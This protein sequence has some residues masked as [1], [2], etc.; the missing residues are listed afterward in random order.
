[1]LTD[2]V[3]RLRFAHLPTP[4]E[5]LPRLSQRLGGPRLFVKRDDQ[6]GLATGGNKTRK[7]EFLVAAAQTEGADTLVTGGA[8][9][10]NHSRQT[11]AA[12]ARVGLRSLLVLRGDPPQGPPQGNLLLDRL[13]G[14]EVRFDTRP[15]AEAL[16][17]AVESLREAGWQPYLIPY[18]GSNPVGA[19]GY[20]AAMEE[21]VEQLRERGERVDY[22]VF[23]TSSGGTQAGLV[24]GARAL[25][26]EGQILG[27]SVDHPAGLLR[28]RLAP[29][30]NDT[31]A[32]LKLDLKFA[33]D[34]FVVNGDYTGGGYG[35][36][37]NLERN[38]IR[39]LAKTE[40]LL[41]DPVY[42]GRAFGGLLDLIEKGAFGRDETVL[43]WHTGGTPALF[44]SP[45]SELLV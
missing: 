26:F 1:M 45:Y 30:A 2:S 31:A 33:A 23:P 9:Q 24:V 38:A 7:L 37:G 3:P 5:E 15:V 11:A 29:L 8:V 25:G 16:S 44:A 40:S 13:V 27:I 10:S 28:Q 22:V 14:A 41:L 43:F 4:I 12:A 36:M 42:T 35:V 39:T 20:V 6:T 32:H 19:T 34:D 17:A 21:L 18:G